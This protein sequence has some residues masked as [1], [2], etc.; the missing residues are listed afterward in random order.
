MTTLTGPFQD[1][2]ERGIQLAKEL[3]RGVAN[4]E[5]EIKPIIDASWQY[6]PIA[7]EDWHELVIAWNSV[8]VNDPCP[9]C[10]NRTDPDIGP[11]LMLDSSRLPVCE[12]CGLKYAPDLVRL[13]RQGNLCDG[14]LYEAGLL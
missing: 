4:L 1:F 10:G 3:A 2:D 9:I 12:D 5:A 14:V 7:G 8:A 6:D 13:L 11:E